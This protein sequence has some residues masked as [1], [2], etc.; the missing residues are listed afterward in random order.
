MTD[1]SN[2]HDEMDGDDEDESHVCEDEDRR[3]AVASLLTII[4]T[5]F[6]N[7]LYVLCR[8][9]VIG[10]LSLG[11]IVEGY[12]VEDNIVTRKTASHWIGQEE[13][14]GRTT[15]IEVALRVCDVVVAQELK[16][17]NYSTDPNVDNRPNRD[18]K[19]L[20]LALRRNGILDGVH[21]TVHLYHLFIRFIIN[22]LL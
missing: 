10:V 16:S 5:I 3:P 4:V 7:V 18:N 2:Q 9:I 8:L 20:A 22:L 11:S 12:I 17:E 19:L 13:S 1:D 14:G 21:L 6:L 15:R